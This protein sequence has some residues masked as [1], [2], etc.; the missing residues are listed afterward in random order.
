MPDEDD[1]PRLPID[2][3]ERVPARRSRRRRERG[4][5]RRPAEPRAL[6]QSPVVQRCGMCGRRETVLGDAVVCRGCGS[7]ILR[8]NDD[9]E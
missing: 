2:L 3:P 8:G 7:L 4:F 1:Q 5:P 6:M 9:E